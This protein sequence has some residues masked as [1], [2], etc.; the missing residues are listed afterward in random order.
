M[1]RQ[2]GQTSVAKR[3][4][5]IFRFKAGKPDLE[6]GKNDQQKLLNTTKYRSL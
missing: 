2:E 6:I 1:A 5:I 4:L 3:E